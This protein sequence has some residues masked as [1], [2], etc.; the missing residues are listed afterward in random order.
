MRR[1]SSAK[2]RV[3]DREL[4][5]LLMSH[6]RYR[7]VPVVCT[8]KSRVSRTKAAGGENPAAAGIRGGEV[9]PPVSTTGWGVGFWSAARRGRAAAAPSDI[10]M[11]DEMK[12]AFVGSSLRAVPF[13]PFAA[14]GAAG[15]PA[16][17][18]WK[19]FT[20]GAAWRKA[21]GGERPRAGPPAPFS[22]APASTEA[23]SAAPPPHLPP[24]P[25]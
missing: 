22:R 13:L 12:V 24:V 15:G 16:V 7:T 6:V 5:V 10:Q 8:R 23:E 11:L 4:P 20:R 9:P 1:G 2:S 14:G 17:T 3:S 18:S 21:A 25:P 19:S